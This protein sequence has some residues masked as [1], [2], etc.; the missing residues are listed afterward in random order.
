MKTWQ[1]TCAFISAVQ[2][3]SVEYTT[4][5]NEVKVSITT[6]S[7]AATNGKINKM[8]GNS[9]WGHS[10][11]VLYSEHGKIKKGSKS[12]TGGLVERVHLDPPSLYVQVL[13]CAMREFVRRVELHAPGRLVGHGYLQC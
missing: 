7:N 13:F 3:I 8:L 9:I 12:K 10:Y 5:G 6:D 2:Y 11:T 4:N 1:C